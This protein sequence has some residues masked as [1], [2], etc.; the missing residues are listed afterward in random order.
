MAKFGEERLYEEV[1]AHLASMDLSS[2]L[3]ADESPIEG[4]MG[5]ALLIAHRL[6]LASGLVIGKGDE[7]DVIFKQ[8]APVDRYRVD[9]LL[10]VRC[11]LPERTGI[12]VECDGHDFHERT[13]EQAAKDKSR[14]RRLAELGYVVLRFTGSEIYRNPLACAAQVWAVA[15]QASLQGVEW[16]DVDGNDTP[17]A[18]KDVQS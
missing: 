17:G 3:G 10:S 1:A 14:D 5:R 15:S 7:A 2:Y 16:P 11:Y 13:K 18:E 4:L 8:Q 12:V 6:G 9:F